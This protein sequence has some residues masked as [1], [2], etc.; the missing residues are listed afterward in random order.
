MPKFLIWVVVSILGSIV[1]QLISVGVYM[2]Q[3]EK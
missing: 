1:L 3:F 2:Q